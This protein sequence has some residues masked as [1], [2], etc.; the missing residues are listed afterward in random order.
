LELSRGQQV[1]LL[2]KSGD[3][4]VRLGRLS[5]ALS[6]YQYAYR[7]EQSASVRK[8]LSA[9]IASVKATLASQRENTSRQPLLHEALEQ[10][11]IVRP[12]LVAKSAPT[13]TGPSRKEVQP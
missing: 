10:D 13:A 11:R 3:A 1:D 7:T 9:T 6:A 5:E 4:M 12:K 8:S 2:Q